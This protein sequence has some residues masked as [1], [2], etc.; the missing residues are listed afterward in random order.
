MLISV[1]SPLVRRLARMLAGSYGLRAAL[2]VSV[3]LAVG[4]CT[5][6][7]PQERA[8]LIAWL[9]Q[10]SN[11]APD[12]GTLR[13]FGDYR[14][15]HAVIGAYLQVQA[16]ASHSIEQALSEL[17]AHSVQEVASRRERLLVLRAS[18]HREQQ[19]LEQAYRQA[20]SQRKDLMQAPDLKVAYDQ[21]FER[22]VTHPQAVM[23]SLMDLLE[24]P[25]SVS[26]KVADFVALHQDQI[27]VAGPVTQVMDPTVRDAL[28]AL[29]DTLNAQ[30]RA[31]QRAAALCRQLELCSTGPGG[32]SPSMAPAPRFQDDL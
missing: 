31:L 22:L 9:Q 14:Q 17:P 5:Q 16:G 19:H 1:L 28:N 2:I 13:R 12:A 6:N 15:H 20:V 4:G 24:E 11:A 25:L 3:A 8:A 7:E 26:L 32:A 29:L 23:V 27:T 10:D 30:S 18:L 21:A